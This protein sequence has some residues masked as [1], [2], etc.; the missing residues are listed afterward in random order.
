MNP[1]ARL[2]ALLEQLSPDAMLPARWILEQLAEE[3]LQTSGNEAAAPLARDLTVKE[4]GACFGK[5]ASTA[6]LWCEQ[7]SVAGAWK[8]NGREW[9]IPLAS[10][11]RFRE[12]QG[13]PPPDT[14][15]PARGSLGDWRRQRKAG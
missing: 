15:R 1:S 3:P 10:V 2:A 8:L 7:G 6:R 14:T 11:E 13:A 5:S 4:F 12:A 9:R